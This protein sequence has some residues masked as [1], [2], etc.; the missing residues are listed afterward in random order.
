M[1]RKTL[2]RCQRG[3]GEEKEE[4]ERNDAH[5]IPQRGFVLFNLIGRHERKGHLP[6]R[7]QKRASIQGWLSPQYRSSN[8]CERRASIL[9]TSRR[10]P[11]TRGITVRS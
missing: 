3:R 4:E 9:R 10:F 11:F 5:G 1:R 6:Q 7:L 8:S 2:P